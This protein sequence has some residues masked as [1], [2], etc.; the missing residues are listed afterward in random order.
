MIPLDIQVASSLSHQ[1]GMTP[2]QKSIAAAEQLPERLKAARKNAGL[3]QDALV[4]LAECAPVTLSKLETGVNSPT[5]EIFVSLAYALGVSPNYL[6]GWQE[7]GIEEVDAERRRLLN[8]LILS[9]QSLPSDWL[10]Q[11]IDIADRAKTKP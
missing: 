5:F 4:T 2:R 6:V 3:T 7:I 9:A 11:L 1:I 10:Q 8:R